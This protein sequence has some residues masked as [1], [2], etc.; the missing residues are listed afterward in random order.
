[1]PWV[2]FDVMAYNLDAQPARPQGGEAMALR[3]VFEYLQGRY[4]G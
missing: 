4:N 1:V 2:H 3:A